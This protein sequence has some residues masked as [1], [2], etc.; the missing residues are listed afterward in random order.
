MID[1]WTL[2]PMI[3]QNPKRSKRTL[4]QPPPAANQTAYERHPVDDPTPML[5]TSNHKD[6]HGRSRNLMKLGQTALPTS[7]NKDWFQHISTCFSPFFS[8]VK[9][10][11]FKAGTWSGKRSLLLE[12]D[13]LIYFFILCMRQRHDMDVEVFERETCEYT[14][15]DVPPKFHQNHLKTQWSCILHWKELC[16]TTDR[17]I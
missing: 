8:S 17:I 5:I 13:I 3:I 9:V 6:S 1:S 4:P 16:T 2:L 11:I 12:D 7:P 15:L 10:A 14:K